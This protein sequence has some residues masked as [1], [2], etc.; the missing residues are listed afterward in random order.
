MAV[1]NST[2]VS[3]T[4]AFSDFSVCLLGLPEL[5]KISCSFRGNW[6]VHPLQLIGKRIRFAEVMLVEVGLFEGEA[7]ESSISVATVLAVELGS[8]EHGIQTRVLLK[9]D[10][11][12]DPYHSNL[13]SL[14][15]LD[16]L[17]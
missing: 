5:E 10:G 11:T 4:P 2:Q 3:A 13:H 15:I 1:F 16:V 8:I 14:T 9:E 17:K 7:F 6:L 12:N